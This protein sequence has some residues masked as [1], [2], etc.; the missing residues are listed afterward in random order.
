MRGST[1]LPPNGS[2]A[3]LG[4][5]DGDRGRLP[6]RQVGKAPEVDAVDLSDRSGAVPQALARGAGLILEEAVTLA[7]TPQ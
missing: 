7:A 5:L 6:E 4:L 3:Y 1:Q 2:C